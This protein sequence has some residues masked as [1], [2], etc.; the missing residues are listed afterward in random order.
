[1][2]GKTGFVER[3]AFAEIPPRVEYHRTE[4]GQALVDILHA[5]SEFAERHLTDD[6]RVSI[7]PLAPAE[8]DAR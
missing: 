6:E 4:K 3:H 8:C 1:M 5:I 7:T 2:L